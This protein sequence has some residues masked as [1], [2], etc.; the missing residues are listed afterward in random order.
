MQ[1]PFLLPFSNYYNFYKIFTNE[2][3]KLKSINRIETEFKIETATKRYFK[4]INTFISNGSTFD[5]S[6]LGMGVDGHVASIFETD[7][8]KPYVYMTR[9]YNGFK[10]ITVSTEILNLCKYNLLIIN[11]V[12]KLNLL[13][14]KRETP[15]HFVKIDKIIFNNAL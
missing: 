4:T 8:L 12:E 11:D 7:F 2:I 9:E 10:R 5:L 1:Q 14:S 3:H 13:K 15:I 6:I